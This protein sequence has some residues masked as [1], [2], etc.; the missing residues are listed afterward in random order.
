MKNKS[1]F[2]EGLL[3]GAVISYTITTL[4]S[5]NE[6]E[7]PKKS[8]KKTTTKKK[9]I[10]RISNRILDVLELGLERVITSLDEQ[11]KEKRKT[12]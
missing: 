6:T 10:S 3:T 7:P 8:T 12:K 5:N 4:I 9:Q 2:L 11:K 1:W